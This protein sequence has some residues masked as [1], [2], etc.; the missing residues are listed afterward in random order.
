MTLDMAGNLSPIPN[1]CG[2]GGGQCGVRK[3]ERRS[4]EAWEQEHKRWQEGLPS[5][6]AGGATVEDNPYL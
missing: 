3:G 6:A 5:S 1:C 4:R 2:E